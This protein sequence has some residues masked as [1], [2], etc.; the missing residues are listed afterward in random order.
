MGFREL[1]HLQRRYSG[2]AGQLVNA[3][4]VP[5]LGQVSRYDPKDGSWKSWKLPGS[6]P[7]VYAVYVDDA[8]KVWL[9]DFTGNAMVRFDPTS[10]QFEV[11]PS[12]RQN[13]G[14]RQIL[15][16]PGEVWVPESGTDHIVVFYTR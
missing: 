2:Q 5:V 16:R 8:D 10:E 15:G 4:Y 7:R 9:S 3:F 11:F 14:V 1:Q 13:A 6:R 12:P